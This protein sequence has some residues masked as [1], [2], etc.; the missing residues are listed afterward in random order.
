MF[1]MSFPTEATAREALT[2]AA[3]KLPVK[4]RIIRREEGEN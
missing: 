4:C 3:H 1:D 2:R